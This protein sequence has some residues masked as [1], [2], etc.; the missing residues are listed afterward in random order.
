MITNLLVCRAGSVDVKFVAS[1]DN[2]RPVASRCGASKKNMVLTSHQ[3]HMC[4]NINA[5]VTN[6]ISLC[7]MSFLH[8]K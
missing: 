8:R 5:Q 6:N 1:V 2:S 3:P 7:T 4:M